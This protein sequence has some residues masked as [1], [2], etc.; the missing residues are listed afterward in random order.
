[1]KGIL[2]AIE[3]EEAR[4]HGRAEHRQE[5]EQNERAI[6]HVSTSD[7]CTA[8]GIEDQ[9]V[10]RTKARSS[11]HHCRQRARGTDLRDEAAEILKQTLKRLVV[12][13]LQVS[14]HGRET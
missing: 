7:A 9:F 2:E 4:P 3:Q 8:V 10:A 5:C 1:M 6:A 12:R 13:E 11:L 14:E